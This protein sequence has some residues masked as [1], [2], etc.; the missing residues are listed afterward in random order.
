MEFELT[1]K[2]IAEAKRKA[3]RHESR[4]SPAAFDMF[5]RDKVVAHEAQKEL[6]K[7]Q[8]G[9]MIKVTGHNTIQEFLAEC[10]VPAYVKDLLKHF[11]LE[12]E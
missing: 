1:D 4:L 6:V 5:G 3:Y 7:W 9:E 11:E 2:Q 8:L 10:I 12:G